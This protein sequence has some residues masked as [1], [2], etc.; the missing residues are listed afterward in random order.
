M[1]IAGRL[2]LP[3]QQTSTD[4]LAALRRPAPMMQTADVA[5]PS[6]PRSSIGS[7][8]SSV[9]SGGTPRDTSRSYNLSSIQQSGPA[10]TPPA[11]TPSTPPAPMP[12]MGAQAMQG[13]GAAMVN[14]PSPGWANDPALDQTA[15]QLG[16]G[17]FGPS[18]SAL[19]QLVQR[20]GLY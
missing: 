15:G 11:P 13:L 20:R 3:Q 19:A 4:P 7:Q 8:P 12:E 14:G 9:T 6:I 5:A 1:A 16:T 10:L 17:T 2:N 18:M